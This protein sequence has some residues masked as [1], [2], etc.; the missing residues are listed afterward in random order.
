MDVTP[1]KALEPQTSASPVAEDRAAVGTGEDRVMTD[2]DTASGMT[3]EAG[4]GDAGAGAGGTSSRVYEYEDPWNVG[5]R[6][7]VEEQGIEAAAQ[8]AAAVAGISLAAGGGGS[9]GAG[10][11]AASSGAGAGPGALTVA[12]PGRLSHPGTGGR[13]RR[14]RRKEEILSYALLWPVAQP[15]SLGSLGTA[16][17]LSVLPTTMP[18][19]PPPMVPLFPGMPSWLQ[20]LHSLR[21]R[22]G[23]DWIQPSEEEQFREHQRTQAQGTLPG[24][25]GAAGAG[26]VVGAS[27]GAGAVDAGSALGAGVNPAH[28]S[29]VLWITGAAA[30]EMEHLSEAE[31]TDGILKLFNMFPSIPLPPG[32]KGQPKISRSQW[33]TDD[34]FLGSY[35]YTRAG[36]EDGEIVDLIAEPLCADSGMPVVMF[37]GEAT[38][39]HFMGTVHGAYMSG[40]REAM[41]YMTALEQQES[42]L[43]GGGR[44]RA[45]EV[46]GVTC[47][48]GVWG[49]SVWGDTAGGVGR[50]CEWRGT[51]CSYGSRGCRF[52]CAEVAYAACSHRCPLLD[53]AHC[54]AAAGVTLHLGFVKDVVFSRASL[55]AIFTRPPSASPLLRQPCCRLG[56]WT[57]PLQV[58]FVLTTPPPAA[59]PTLLHPSLLQPSL[60]HTSLLHPPLPCPCAAG[61]EHGV[62]LCRC[63]RRTAPSRQ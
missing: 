4:Q 13:S 60:P 29:A 7:M 3:G 45:E 61:L 22:P 46:C 54:A 27:A 40:F 10:A 55:P 14:P 11:A 47:V 18:Y 12:A 62:C 51:W 36:V 23:P 6:G 21:F 52:V 9:G 63:G 50:T 43:V 42:M 5:R 19:V 39:R 37:A 56:A 38:H 16:Q 8:A 34:L 48:L 35:S 30:L 28:P 2:S 57:L 33:G 25:P 32:A 49:G 44:C 17:A 41:R 59:P 24:A 26:A 53:A 20:G 15:L 1:A 31:V 58:L